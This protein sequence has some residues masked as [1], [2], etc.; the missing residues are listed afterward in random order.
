MGEIH[1]GSIVREG[2][3]V[4]ARRA[5]EVVVEPVSP[6]RG[7]L[8]PP[9]AGAGS[10]RWRRRW[11]RL[12]RLMRLVWRMTGWRRRRSS[13]GEAGEAGEG[14]WRGGVVVIDAVAG[15]V[16]VVWIGVV[17]G[18]HE[19]PEGMLLGRHDDSDECVVL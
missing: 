2:M 15:V 9:G 13:E 12:V 19:V 5:V 4:V 1:A 10:G 17:E 8:I 7:S 14:A 3:F 18:L 16:A 6:D 11:M